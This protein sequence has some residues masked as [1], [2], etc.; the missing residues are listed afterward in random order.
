MSISEKSLHKAEQCWCD[1]KTEHLEMIPELA[2]AISTRFDEYQKKID[3]LKDF[4]IWMTGCGYDFCQHEYFLEQRDILLKDKQQYDEIVKNS[5]WLRTLEFNE[6]GKKYLRSI[7]QYLVDDSADVYAVL[8]A[9]EVVCPARA[10]AI[11]KLLCSGIRRKG[12]MK[13]DLEE[14]RDAIIRAIQIEEAIQENVDE[15]VSNK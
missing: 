14:A 13:Q 8:L 1:K 4:A 2:E 12:S 3:D 7:V 10:H 15:K 11:K 6:S 5:D 9:F